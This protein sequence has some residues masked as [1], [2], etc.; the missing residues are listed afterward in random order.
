MRDYLKLLEQVDVWALDVRAKHPA[1]VPCTRGCFDCC[2]GLFDISPAD[3]DLLRAGLAGL[4][5][6][7]RRDIR[8]RARRLLKNLKLGKTLEGWSPEEIDAICDAHGSA[9]C[10][11]LGRGGACRLYA[12][13]PLPCRLAGA[14]LVNLSGRVIS[15]AACGKCTLPPRKTPRFDWAKIRRAERRILRRRY[16]ARAGITLLIPQ[17]LA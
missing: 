7:A 10:P 16:G 8:S 6:A 9:R 5:A 13:R 1:R 4:D 2:L 15:D 11:V 3:A 14:P 12:H 17:A